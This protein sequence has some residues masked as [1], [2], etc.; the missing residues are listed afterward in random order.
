MREYICS[1][2]CFVF[3]FPRGA[4]SAASGLHCKSNETPNRGWRDAIPNT[5]GFQTSMS[6]ESKIAGRLWHYPLYLTFFFFCFT[7]YVPDY[8]HHKHLHPLSESPRTTAA[9]SWGLGFALSTVCETVTM[10][11]MT[12]HLTLRLIYCTFQLAD[13]SRCVCSITGGSWRHSVD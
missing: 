6:S 9:C 5:G 1:D 3:R 4:L 7:L 8:H 12:L 11:L 10:S 2:S 13:S